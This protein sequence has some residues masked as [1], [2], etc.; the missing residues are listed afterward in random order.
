MFKLFYVTFH[1]L[2]AAVYFHY[3]CH[4]NC[5]NGPNHL[6]AFTRVHY[7]FYPF[8]PLQFSIWPDFCSIF[9]LFLLYPHF[10][11]IFYTYP[12]CKLF[13]FIFLISNN[14]LQ[15]LSLYYKTVFCSSFMNVNYHFLWLLK[16]IIWDFFCYASR[17]VCLLTVFFCLCCCWIFYLLWWKLY[18]TSSWLLAFSGSWRNAVYV[19]VGPGDLTE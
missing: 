14:S 2:F 7:S 16:I 18:S 13:Y 9:H 11:D 1:L 4:Y 10:W 15:A 8:G 12:F 6:P 17:I 3:W 5:L 19:L